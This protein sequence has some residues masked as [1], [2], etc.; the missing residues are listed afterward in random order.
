M[1]LSGEWG[2][3]L[4]PKLDFTHSSFNNSYSE[5]IQGDKLLAFI[6]V[7][8]GCDFL[9][10]CGGSRKLVTIVNGEAVAVYVGKS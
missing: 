5:Q 7:C 8:G 9:C 10:S 2:T 3:P 1:L 6:D 4:L